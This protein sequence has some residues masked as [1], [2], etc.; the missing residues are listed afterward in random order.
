MSVNLA[1]PPD[2]VP[3]GLEAGVLKL[4]RQARTLLDLKVIPYYIQAQLGD[5]GYITVED[6]ADRW[7]T[8]E[9]ARVSG[10]KELKFEANSNDYTAEFQ[11]Y[12]QCVYTK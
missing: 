12:V 5:A 11:N 3:P 1:K 2:Q 7:H 10:P 9:E 8:A 4:T 6:L